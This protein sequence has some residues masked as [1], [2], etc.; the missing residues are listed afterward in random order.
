MLKGLVWYMRTGQC[1]E[2]S[3]ESRCIIAKLV[4]AIA[5]RKPEAEIASAFR[6]CGALTQHV[7]V[8][9]GSNPVNSE[10]NCFEMPC[11]RPGMV[12]ENDEDEF[13]AKF[14]SLLFGKLQPEMIMFAWIG[15]GWLGSWLGSWLRSWLRSWL[16]SWLVEL[17]CCSLGSSL[18][19]W[20][21]G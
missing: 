4:V 9:S 14:A 13:M 5:E 17:L 20:L 6:A 18:G 8:D 21:C 3:S 16:G 11:R 15:I 7:S 2:L 12:T 19:S 1:K 10:S